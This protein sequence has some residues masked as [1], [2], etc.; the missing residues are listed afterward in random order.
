MAPTLSTWLRAPHLQRLPALL[1][2]VLVRRLEAGTA[3]VP[4]QSDATRHEQLGGNTLEGFLRFMWI[5][6][7]ECKTRSPYES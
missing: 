7:D 4:W 3:T 5:A 1:S 6:L 2:L